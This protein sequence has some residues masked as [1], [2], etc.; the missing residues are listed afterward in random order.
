MQTKIPAAELSFGMFVAD[1]DRPWIDTPFLFQGFLIEND[2]HLILLRKY[3][4]HVLVDAMRSTQNAQATISAYRE[5]SGA[6]RRD[7]AAKIA[8]R[9]DNDD[10]IAAQRYV[11]PSFIPTEITLTRFRN[12]IPV[13]AEL[14]PAGKAYTR[15]G[16]V[17]RDLIQDIRSDKQLAL[18]EV[19]V[20][21]QDVVDTMVRNPDALMLVARLQKQ[22]EVIYGHGLNV[23]IYLVALGRHLGLPKDFLERLGTI[24]LLLDIGKTRLPRELLLKKGRLTSAE[25][26]MAKTHVA[27]GLEILKET[28]GLHPDILQGIAQHHEREDGSGYPAGLSRG[29]IGLFGRM[30]AI[31]DSFSAL[32]NPR[33]YAEVIPAYEALQTMGNWGGQF[34]HAPVVEQFIHAIGIFPVG[35]MVEL[36]SGEVAVVISHNKVRRLKPRVLIISGPDKRPSTS[37]STVD[38]LYPPATQK[39]ALSILHG[40]PTGA[41]GLNPR[42]YYL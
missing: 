19:E 6:N 34:Y 23:A 14:A 30:A 16:E 22:D 31:A 1:L 26:E 18:E 33:P 5:K 4:K 3:C 10:S 2:E 13:E 27:L 24:G 11:R 20:V 7:F 9:A 37:P 38:L 8:M 32:T 41:Y 39:I 12:I 42:E 28:P 29:D 25:F 36:S 40:L 35:S 15:T 21:I 17:L